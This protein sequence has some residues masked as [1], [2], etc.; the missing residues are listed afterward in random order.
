MKEQ[1]KIPTSRL[2]RAGKFINTGAKVGGNYIKYYGKRFISGDNDQEGLQRKNAD[3]I[4]GAL[5]NLKG[6]ALKIAQM[7]SM[8]QGILPQAYTTKF[9]QAQYSAPPLSYPLVVKTFTQHFG[10]GPSELYDSFTKNAVAAASIGQVHQAEKDGKKLAVKV[11]Y[12]GVADAIGSD[13]RIVRPLVGA[14]FNISNADMDHYLT[15]VKERLME[16]TDYELELNRSKEISEACK[17]IE[18]L[19]FPEYYTE[20]SAPRILTMDWMDGMH[21]DKFM[22]TNPSQEVRDSIG[23]TLWDF[24]NFQ[25]HQLR[26]L[27]ADP[28]PGNFLLKQ[29]GTV[30]VIDFGCVKVLND[31]FYETYFKLMEPGVA[32]DE[33]AFTNLL[34]EL[35]F[36]LQADSEGEKKYFTE[37]Y[38]EMHELLGRPF[39]SEEFDFADKEYFATIFMQGERLSNDK[40]LRKANAARGPR[41]AIYLNRTYFGLYTLLHQLG[42]RVKTHMDRALSPVV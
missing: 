41:D 19:Q 23:Q 25:I 7:M 18:Y 10:K 40:T 4:Y 27:H 14:L 2:Q 9:A 31:E 32:N 26:Q 30:G 21:L 22:E 28:H 12:P 5:S 29:D 15:E 42:A 17:H 13:L 36:L 35:K 38:A 6:G 11:Q 3:D 24:Y 1:D 16:E 39:F 34:N 37:L 8:D 20:L 33:A